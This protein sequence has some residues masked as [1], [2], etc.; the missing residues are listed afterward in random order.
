MNYLV[1]KHMSYP[2]PFDVRKV[3]DEDE[4]EADKSKQDLSRMNAKS[5]M[6]LEIDP[7]RDAI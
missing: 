4:D 5:G 2:G 7:E 3:T 1:R 6:D